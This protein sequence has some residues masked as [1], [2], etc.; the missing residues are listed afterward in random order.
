MMDEFESAKIHALAQARRRVWWPFAAMAL[1]VAAVT[2]AVA[3][4]TVGN[5]SVV[6]NTLFVTLCL[7]PTLLIM[8]LLVVGVFV[9]IWGLSRADKL[10]V[11]RLIKLERSA[12]E[13]RGRV[14]TKS[15]S[16]GNRF[17]GFAAVIE[18]LEPLWSVFDPEDGVKGRSDAAQSKQ[19]DQSSN[20]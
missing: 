10:T 3:L 8:L 18:R 13:A 5:I 20:A 7:L 1:L 9:G 15:I 16:V 14:Q 17:I 19:S 11:Q 12:A 4:L 2:A 6:T